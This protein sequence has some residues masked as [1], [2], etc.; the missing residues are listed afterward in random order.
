MRRAS[1]PSGGALSW[2]SQA[3]QYPAEGGPG[4]VYFS[5]DTPLGDVDCLLFYDR[6]KRLRGILNYYAID[7][8]PYEKAGNVNVWVHPSSQRR[9]IGTA[10][11]MEAFERW[12]IDLDG[13]RFTP[14]GLRLA[15]VV[16]SKIRQGLLEAGGD[17]LL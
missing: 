14:E 11:V 15:D 6:K 9:G 3:C 13:Q 8:P 1:I 2:E 4:I 17:V 7:F 12:N 5:G 16:E 10:L